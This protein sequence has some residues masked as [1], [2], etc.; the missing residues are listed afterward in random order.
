MAS[1]FWQRV[2]DAHTVSADF[3]RVAAM[4]ARKLTKAIARVA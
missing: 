4:Q 3:R 2:A 1:E